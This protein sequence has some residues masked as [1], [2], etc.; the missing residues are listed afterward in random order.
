MARTAD[1]IAQELTT[2]IETTDSTLDTT[3]GPIPD[4]LIRP[5]SGQI[6]IAEADA[7]SLRQLFTLQ[8][9]SVATDDEVKNALANFGSTPGSGAFSK[10]IQYFMRFTRP[11]ED[12]VIPAGSLVSN[13]DGT[14]VYKV[15]NEG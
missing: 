11:T 5:Q 6:A 8:F 2:S 12:I 14:M 9:S 1:Q 15:I 10:T 3:Q 13:T 7:E 4:I